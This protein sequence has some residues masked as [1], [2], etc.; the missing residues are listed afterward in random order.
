MQALPESLTG[1]DKSKSF[2]SILLNTC[3]DQ[4]EE[5][6]N[7]RAVYLLPN[8]DPLP[9]DITLYSNLPRL[10]LKANIFGPDCYY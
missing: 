6:A 5:A 3:Q 1:A 7:N 8:L 4:F 9:W 10:L 2:K